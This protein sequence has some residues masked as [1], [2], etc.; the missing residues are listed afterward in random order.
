MQSADNFQAEG[1]VKRIYPS[2]EVSREVAEAAGASPGA[3][4]SMGTSIRLSNY[5]E[6]YFFLPISHENY[7]ALFSLALVAAT[8]QYQLA[9]RTLEEIKPGE[10]VDIWYMLVDW[11]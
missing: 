6:T 11:N 10:T 4:G 5:P 9:I 3:V 7:N 8:N 2:K 1:Q